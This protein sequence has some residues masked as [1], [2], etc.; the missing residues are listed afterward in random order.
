MRRAANYVREQLDQG[1]YHCSYYLQTK[2]NHKWAGGIVFRMWPEFVGHFALLVLMAKIFD[3]YKQELTR[4]QNE[5][6]LNEGQ[7]PEKLWK[8]VA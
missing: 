7:S 5:L 4:L 6:A 1:H 3:F 8:E 2:V